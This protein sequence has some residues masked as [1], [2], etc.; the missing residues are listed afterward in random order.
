MSTTHFRRYN[1]G[2]PGSSLSLECAGNKRA[3]WM[4]GGRQ[5]WYKILLLHSLEVTLITCQIL[6]MATITA[7]SEENF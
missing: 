1:T 6:N 5:A 4:T 2:N 7:L 3:G